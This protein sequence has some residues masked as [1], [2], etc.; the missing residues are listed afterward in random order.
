MRHVDSDARAIRVG[1]EPRVEPARIAVV[2]IAELLLELDV[3]LAK[4]GVAEAIAQARCSAHARAP[5]IGRVK[6]RKREPCLVPQKNQVGLDGKAL[7]HHA[8]HVVDDAVKRAIGEENELHP[9][10]LAGTFLFE[11]ALLDRPDRNCAVHRV[12]VQP[13]CVQVHD[14]RA[15]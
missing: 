7:L 6:T 3:A 8:F 11:Q 9:V 10:E 4:L 1:D 15:R 2:R 5:A 14:M 12:L 13:I